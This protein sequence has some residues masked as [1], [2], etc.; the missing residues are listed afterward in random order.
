MKIVGTSMPK[1]VKANESADPAELEVA[2]L[3]SAIE[4]AQ[5][6]AR[7]AYEFSS[8]CSYARLDGGL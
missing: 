2:E 7:Q 6:R 5:D 4:E 8:G 1:S 3:L